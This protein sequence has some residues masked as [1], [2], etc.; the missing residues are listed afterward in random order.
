MMFK[1]ILPTSFAIFSALLVLGGLLFDQYPQLVMAR[2][3][4]LQS[5]MVIA[6]FAF[7]L[8]FVNLLRV[9]LYRLGRRGPWGKRLASL[10]IVLSAVGTAGLVFLDGTD[11]LWSQRILEG[12]LIPGEGALLALTAITLILAAMRMLRVRRGMGS[13][14]FVIVLT[15]SLLGA[16]PYVPGLSALAVWLRDVPA[17]AGMRGLLLGV[18]LG[19]ALTALRIMLGFSQ[20]HSD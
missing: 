1:R 14:I 19:I 12:L 7:I 20:P 10:L 4:L 16:L 6:A 8:A 5:A 2:A 17:M 9:H 13:L 18:A 3:I 11:G 15:L